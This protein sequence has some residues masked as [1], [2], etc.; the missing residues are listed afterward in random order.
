MNSK[1]LTR[2]FWALSCSNM[3]L[4]GC[5]YWCLKQKFLG[6]IYLMIKNVLS[7]Q[8]AGINSVSQPSCLL[9]LSY[10]TQR[11]DVDHNKGVSAYPP[12]S[13]KCYSFQTGSYLERV[14]NN[15]RL[16]QR[17]EILCPRISPAANT[18]STTIRDFPARSSH[19]TGFSF[20]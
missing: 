11:C 17:E 4:F 14:R 18:S 2:D 16:T 10:L 19:F 6:D 12:G 8:S 9:W 15:F 1:G 3:C 7:S 20:R 5:R 13:D